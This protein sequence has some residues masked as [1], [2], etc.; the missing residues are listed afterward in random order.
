MEIF[1]RDFCSLF[2]LLVV[3]QTLLC[4]NMTSVARNNLNFSNGTFSSLLQKVGFFPCKNIIC[5][6]TGKFLMVPTKTSLQVLCYLSTTIIHFGILCLLINLAKTEDYKNVTEFSMDFFKNGGGFNSKYDFN[7][8][9]SLT[10]T[11]HIFHFI[12][13]YFI[14]NNYF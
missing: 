7:V 2:V 6:E 1:H 12:I 5:P 4:W 9:E 8:F 14:R 10:T 11:F 13:F 3:D